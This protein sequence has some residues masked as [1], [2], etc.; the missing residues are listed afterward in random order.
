M[1]RLW[2]RWGA[3]LGVLGVGL[4]VIALNLDSRVAEH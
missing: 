3:S 4:C 2:E 1:F